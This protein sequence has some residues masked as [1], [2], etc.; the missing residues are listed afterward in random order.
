MLKIT[1]FDSVGR[2]RPR[3]CLPTFCFLFFLSLLRDNDI[4]CAG[5]QRASKVFFCFVHEW[6]YIY[7]TLAWLFLLTIFV[8]V[9]PAQHAGS[10]DTK[11]IPWLGNWLYSIKHIFYLLTF[12][13]NIICKL[14]NHV[15]RQLLVV[16]ISNTPLV[17]IKCSTQEFSPP[18]I[19]WVH[20]WIFR[21]Q[22]TNY[23]SINQCLTSWNSFHL[24]C[25]GDQ[26]TQHLK[27]KKNNLFFLVRKINQ[28]QPI[29]IMDVRRQEGVGH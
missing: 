14:Q 20:N 8:Y 5:V 18:V 28:Q 1:H 9:L 17:C 3:R 12:D 23:H 29:I 6:M 15:H 27:D 19:T 25:Y 2:T 13:V 4:R 24:E 16:H 10:G 11:C 7:N 21:V 26:S 22:K